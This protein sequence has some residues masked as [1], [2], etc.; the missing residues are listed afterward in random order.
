MDEQQTNITF[1]KRN[2]VF[3]VINMFIDLDII[4]SQLKEYKLYHFEALNMYN[5]LAT[6]L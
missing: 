6:L 3:I 1:S 2:S 4:I 5:L